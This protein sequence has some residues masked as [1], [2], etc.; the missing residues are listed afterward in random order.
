MKA[1]G[2]E[3]QII[4]SDDPLALEQAVQAL[5][6]GGLVAFPTDTVYGLGA[7][8]FNSQAVEQLYLVKGR[9]AAKAIAV[10]VGSE[11]DLPQVAQ[12]LGQVAARLARRFWPGPLTLVVPAHPRL[13]PNLSPLPTVGVRMPDHPVALA[14]LRRTGPLAVTSANLSGQPS[15]CSAGEVYAQLSGRIP[16]ILDGGQTPGGK[17]STVVDCTGPEL[18]ILRQ[19]PISERQLNEAV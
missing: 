1:G 15:A 3:T 14:L 12:E 7:M 17:P 4:L 19:G 10:L 16:L 2:L 11:E 18:V 8:L 6:A 9:E 13:P 5:Q